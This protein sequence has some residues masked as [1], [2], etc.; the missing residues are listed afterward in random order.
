MRMINK[1][2]NIFG[3]NNTYSQNNISE[4]YNYYSSEIETLLKSIDGYFSKGDI[5]E[6]FNLLNSAIAESKHKQSKYPLFLKKIEYLLETRNVDEAKKVIGLLSKDYYEHID[7]KYKEHLLFIYSLEKKEKDFFEMVEEIKSEKEDIKP[8]DY[9]KIVY[10]LNSGNLSDAKNLFEAYSDTKQ[11]DNYLIGGHIFANLYTQ[12]QDKIYLEKATEFYQIVLDNEPSFLLKMHVDG[13][14]VQHII[15]EAYQTRNDFDK[16]KVL[17]FK[18]TL[19]KA[20]EAKKYFN[21]TYIN[22]EINFYAFILFVLKFKDEYIQFYDNHTSVLFNEHC[23]Q[24]YHIRNIDIEHSTVQKNIVKS[25]RLLINYASLMIDKAEQNIVLD[26]FEKNYSLLFK[27]DLLIYFY[28]QSIFSLEH[29]IIEE[30]ES[31]I[32][33]EKLKSYELYQSYLLLKH[34]NTQAIS[35]DEVQMLLSFVDDEQVIY[36]KVVETINFLEKIKMSKY[37]VLLATSKIHQF[38]ELIGYTLTKCW[39]DKELKLED[40]ELFIN[41]VDDIK[42]FCQVQTKSAPICSAKVHHF[43]TPI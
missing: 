40:F 37:Y 6:A 14:F 32:N 15:N 35:N 13:F 28:L 41:C 36:A 39:H 30:I 2:L 31:Y 34:Y 11:K 16:K 43:V 38:E 42:Y 27:F 3:S 29:K 21:K 19:N 24:Y 9:F 26:F 5:T 23:L 22:Q 33:D 17:Q 18:T 8:D 4:Q 25:D 7:T 20:F 1:I 12:T 10:S